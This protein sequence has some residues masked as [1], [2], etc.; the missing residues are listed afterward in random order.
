MGVGIETLIKTIPNF[1]PPAQGA[2]TGPLFSGVQIECFYNPYPY[3]VDENNLSLV[4]YLNIRG[5]S[6]LF[7][8]DMEKAGFE[9]MLNT[10]E[11][12][13]T[14]VGSLDILMAS[15][16]G[17]ENGICPDM[18][19]KWGCSPK[20]VVISDDY[21]QYDTQETTSYYESKCSGITNFRTVGNNRKV[22]STRKDGEILFTF[23]NGN[24]IVS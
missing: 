17:R 12:F 18:F 14:V 22:L 13:R 5:F 3:Y 16:H 15:H 7:P 9:N 21:K 20:L 19:D 8:G 24:C 23:K 10:N 1:S 6:F 11:R 2:S 4:L